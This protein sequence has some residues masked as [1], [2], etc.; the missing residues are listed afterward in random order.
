N[1]PGLDNE[2]EF[3]YGLGFFEREGSNGE[4]I[5]QHDGDADGYTVFYTLV[6]SKNLGKVLMTSS[7]GNWFLD[8]DKQIEEKIFKWF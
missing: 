6:P 5:Y 2:M 7:G 1:R 4:V 8:L 3:N